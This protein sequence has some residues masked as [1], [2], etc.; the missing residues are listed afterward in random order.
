MDEKIE[1][2]KK[3]NKLEYYAKGKRSFVYRL[4]YK[5]K[6]AVLKEESA[7][8][9]AICRIQNEANWL[10]AL[11]KEGIGPKLYFEGEGF[12]VMEFVKG[13]RIIEWAK[14][15]EK[16]DLR[17]VLLDVMKQCRKMDIM[18]VS[19]E[20]MHNPW[21]HIII[22]KAPIMIDFERCHVD[23][24][25]KNVTQFCQFL[26]SEKFYR[27]LEAKGIEFEKGKIIAWLKSYKSGKDVFNEIL[28][29]VSLKSC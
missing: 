24:T 4:K 15:S 18:R 19:K 8:S 2:F 16:E 12:I 26:M 21:K 23:I 11:N 22:D 7:N 10:R 17:K 20:E 25:P 28:K 14:T 5:N 3:S 9:T 27:I 6:E 29:A 13:T 1:D